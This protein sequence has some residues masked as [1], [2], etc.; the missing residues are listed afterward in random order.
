MLRFRT[1]SFCRWN[2]IAN[3]LYGVR[4]IASQRQQ[5]TASDNSSDVSVTKDSFQTQ[6]PHKAGRGKARATIKRP[7]HPAIRILELAEPTRLCCELP[8]CKFKSAHVFQLCKHLRKRH[9]SRYARQ[10]YFRTHDF[11]ECSR[12]NQVFALRG[13][14]KCSPPSNPEGDLVNCDEE[15]T[16]RPQGYLFRRQGAP[17]LGH[18][19]IN[20]PELFN[21]D[22]NLSKPSLR[23]YGRR[24]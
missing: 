10:L 13:G 14:H 22:I 24:R 17:G 6:T 23:C 16:A 8:G 2:T 7:S 12:C 15:P 21:F 4:D 1:P 3:M 19:E 18:P 11:F 9:D 5:Q 20:V